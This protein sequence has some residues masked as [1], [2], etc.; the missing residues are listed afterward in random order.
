[1]SRIPLVEKNDASV[2]VNKVYNELEKQGFSILNVF[3]MFANKKARIFYSKCIQNV[4][5]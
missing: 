3:K 2:E 1:M 4:C 5:E